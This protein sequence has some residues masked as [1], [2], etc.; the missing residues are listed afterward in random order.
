MI[1]AR[2]L[3]AAVAVKNNGDWDKEYLCIKNK[4][5]LT[6]EE[7]EKFSHLADQVVTILDEDYP[8]TWK[9]SVKPPLI[10]F[11]K[12]GERSLLD[13]M[14]WF[15]PHKIMMSSVFV[16]DDGKDPQTKKIIDGI[17]EHEGFIAIPE[18]DSGNIVLKN[19]TQSL[20]LS[21][22]PSGAYDANSKEQ[23]LR[24]IQISAGL[25]GKLFVG[26]NEDAS[27][28]GIA[29]LSARNNGRDVCVAPTS[30]GTAYENNELLREGADI[31]LDWRDVISDDDDDDDED[32]DDN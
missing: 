8:M 29:V 13:E 32:D 11:Y 6:N 5:M 3:L 26:I 20:T 22:Y 28:V 23:R 31:A 27:T 30:L 17:L 2:E 12:G 19:K 9:S 18:L 25:C 1:K 21:E 10:L 15:S 16:L 7:I 4:E 24:V 14:N